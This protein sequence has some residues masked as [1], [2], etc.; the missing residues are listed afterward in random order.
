MTNIL[1]SVMQ[2]CTI[3]KLCMPLLALWAMNCLFGLQTYQAICTIC[4]S[5]GI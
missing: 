5:F 3:S 4:H 2:Y 1:G